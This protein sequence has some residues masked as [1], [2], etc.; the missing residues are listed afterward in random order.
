MSR[1]PRCPHCLSTALSASPAGVL[2]CHACAARLPPPPTHL[3]APAWQCDA[4]LDGGE[5]DRYAR[6][7]RLVERWGTSTQREDGA[8]P[9]EGEEREPRVRAPAERGAA[10]DAID[11]AHAELAEQTERTA[12]V[13]RA[14]AREARRSPPRP[15]PRR[16]PRRATARDILVEHVT[17]ALLDAAPPSALYLAASS[18][19]PA[20][21]RGI[22]HGL[23]HVLANALLARGV[24]VWALLGAAGS[25]DA[26]AP[27]LPRTTPLAGYGHALALLFGDA[28]TLGGRS[29]VPGGAAARHPLPQGVVFGVASVHPSR[30]GGGSAQGL[31]ALL[32]L[33]DVRAAVGAVRMHRRTESRDGMAVVVD[34]GRGLDA[35]DLALLRLADRG[36]ERARATRSKAG[37]VTPALEPMGAKGAAR[38]A[39]GMGGATERQVALRLK[40]A[41]R[42]L[43]DALRERGMIPAARPPQPRPARPEPSPPALAASLIEPTTSIGLGQ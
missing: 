39:A 8:A 36:A 22:Q 35:E 15:R 40:G 3:A 18:L 17:G 12:D 37:K 25:I 14:V 16:A 33:V 38:A 28:P 27:R 30:S 21:L 20:A 7:G 23:A 5:W 41:K 43:E 26:V 10:D 32:A 34:P 19:V 2:D 31:D 24:D 11:R 1:L 9:R 13:L 4:R 42:G 29:P 6:P